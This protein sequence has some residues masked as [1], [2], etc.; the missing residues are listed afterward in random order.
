M[1][2]ARTSTLVPLGPKPT[3]SNYAGLINPSTS[4]TLS[5]T[6][7][8]VSTPVSGQ[9]IGSL[10]SFTLPPLSPAPSPV[11]VSSRLVASNPSRNN[12][13]PSLISS[14]P[15]PTRGVPSETRSSLSSLQPLP[16]SPLALPALRNPQVG[17]FPT[18]P[19]NVNQ[20]KLSPLPSL[21]ALAQ[22]PRSQGPI[23]SNSKSQLSPLPPPPKSQLGS[24]PSRLSPLPSPPKSLSQ[25]G[26]SPSRLSPL[27]SPPKSQM[28][29]RL[30]ELIPLAPLS[31]VPRSDLSSVP[32]SD[33]SSVPRSDLSSVPRSDLSSVPR[34]DLS[35]VPRSDLSS[36]PRSDLSSVPRS[37]LSSVPRSDLSSVPRSDLSS[38]PRSDLSSD[39]SEEAVEKSLVSKGWLPVDKIISEDDQGNLMCRYI[40]AVDPNGRTAYVE[41]DCEGYVT[42]D[43]ENM[44]LVKGSGFSNV[45][46]SVKMGSYESSVP[47]VNGVAIECDG[48]VCTMVRG[49]TDPVESVYSRVNKSSNSVLKAPIS[50]PIVSMKAL[51]TDNKTIEEN[52]K[53]THDRMRNIMFGQTRNGR[54]NLTEATQDLKDEVDRFDKTQNTVA[55]KLYRTVAELEQIRDSYLSSPIRNATEQMKL[56]VINFNLRK[57][58]DLTADLLKLSDSV[59]SRV[60]KIREIQDEIRSLNDLADRLFANVDYVYEA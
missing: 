50:Y 42:V 44:S 27:P 45:P 52:V 22:T 20:S 40:K 56:D 18:L 47:D 8:P 32:R 14:T 24:S 57:R 15:S 23:A 19:S 41:M 60:S 55:S 17:T 35:S 51:Q 37:D 28:P 26:S 53:R 7:S 46:Y 4:S 29:P 21:P 38:V 59:T 16:A 12:V 25:L 3:T 5:S 33:L 31:S 6:P 2:I 9:S 49:E 54:K 10:K 11:P 43:P 36:V 34:S 30:R 1:S 39:F 58:N 13:N 48:E